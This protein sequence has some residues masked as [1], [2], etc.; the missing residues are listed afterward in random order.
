MRI[1]CGQYKGRKYS[2]AIPEGIRPTT[3][4]LRESIFN[5]LNNYTDFVN[6]VVADICAGTGFMGFEALSRGASHC[7][8]FEKSKKTV[9]LI[10]I[11]ASQFKIE[12]C[13]VITG[14]ALKKLKSFPQDQNNVIFDLIFFDPPYD[15]NLY[16]SVINSIYNNDLLKKEGLLVIEQPSTLN[17]I[18]PKTYIIINERI[19]GSTK[20]LIIRNVK[21]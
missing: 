4:N 7:Y 8:F 5:I 10:K 15:S 17:L 13:L 16:N 21:P 9:E 2:G 6:L 12:N 14:D 3:D 11:I 20:L 1:I 19:F 18:L